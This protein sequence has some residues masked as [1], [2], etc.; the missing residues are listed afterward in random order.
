MAYTET[1]KEHI[2]YIVTCGNKIYII[3]SYVQ[4]VSISFSPITF[5]LFVIGYY[6]FFF[7]YQ[8]L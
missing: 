1:Y 4:N 5:L 7:P 2:I 8:H 3:N 6:K